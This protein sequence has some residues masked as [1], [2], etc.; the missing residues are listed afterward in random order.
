MVYNEFTF[1]ATQGVEKN[2]EFLNS[3]GLYHSAFEPIDDSDDFYLRGRFTHFGH[4]KYYEHCGYWR[5]DP[6]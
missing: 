1:T 5:K 3:E 2:R 4:A 6:E